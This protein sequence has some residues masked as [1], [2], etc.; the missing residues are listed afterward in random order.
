MDEDRRASGPQHDSNLTVYKVALNVTSKAT[1]Q[2]YKHKPEDNTSITTLLRFHFMFRN[3][4]RG[5]PRQAVVAGRVCS[6]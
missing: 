3:L 1:R 2:S 4:A 5:H 6:C